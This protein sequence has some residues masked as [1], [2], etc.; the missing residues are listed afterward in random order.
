LGEGDIIITKFLISNLLFKKGG[1]VPKTTLIRKR[2]G[3]IVK[4]DP[5]KITNAILKAFVATNFRNKKIA[6]KLTQQVVGALDRKFKGKIPGVEDVQDIVE[7]ILIKNGLAQ[8]AKAYILYRQKRAEIRQIKGFLGPRDELNFSVNATKVLQKRYLL[9]DD[10]GNVI[11]TPVQ[12]FR[13]VAKAVALADKEYGAKSSQIKKTEEDFYQMMSN[14]EFLPNSPTLMNAGTKIGQLSACFVLPVKDSIEEI[15]EALKNMAIIH[16]SG[17]GTGF[18]F[19]HLRP[20]GDL[21]ASTKGSASGPV[22]FMRIFDVATEVIKQGGKRR[23]ANMGILNVS[24]PDIFEFITAK[25]KE[26]FLTNFN[27]SVAVDEK[28]MQ[29]TE[30]NLDYELINPKNK[31]VVKKVKARDIFDL[32]VNSA[33]QTGDPGLIFIERINKDN[34]TPKIGII[35]STNPCGEQPLLP[36][37]SCNLGSINLAKMVKNKT[38]DWEKL[39]D[40]VKKAVHFLDNVIDV[41]KFPLPEIEKI[42]KANRKIGLGIMGFAEMLIQL[43]I[44]YNSPQAIQIADELMQFISQRARE[45]SEELAKQ[46]SSFPNFYESVWK[47]KGYK[48]MRNATLTTIAPTGTISIIANCSSGIEPL[49]AVCFVRNVMEGTK[50]LEINPYFEKIARERGFYSEEL[51]QKIAKSGSLAEIKEVPED[52]KRIFVTALDISPSWHIRMQAAFQ[53]HVDNAVSK[54]IN[55]PHD[56]TINDV[57]DAFLLAYK[58]G[59]KGITVYRYGCKKEQVLYIGAFEKELRPEAEEHISAESEYAGG[60]PGAYCPF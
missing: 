44:P 13:R 39:A 9:K 40:V 20:K 43:K 52:V 2:D 8:V 50:L 16:K 36:Y 46:R 34:P 35:E 24:H 51:M 18:S 1:I 49:F 5:E 26:G 6:E 48:Q 56:A 54:T 60:C 53:R 32:I 10:E 55:L 59:C 38:I 19:S 21:I 37:E 58:S 4:F 31:K 17:G 11:E 14:L 22:S 47:E 12:M 29:A 3:R 30:R 41:N 28:F 7:E 45:T 27:L 25:T 15:F 42:T 57:R 33:W 23:G